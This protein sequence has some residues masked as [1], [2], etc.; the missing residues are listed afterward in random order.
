MKRINFK[1]FLD[2]YLTMSI[3]CEK[4]VRDKVNACY[5]VVNNFYDENKITYDE[6]DELL[7]A[8]YRI[9]RIQLE[10]IAN[11]PNLEIILSRDDPDYFYKLKKLHKRSKKNEK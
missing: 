3:E 2:G 10:L 1:D 11:C 4:D 9:Q 7:D 8:F 5:K 6:L